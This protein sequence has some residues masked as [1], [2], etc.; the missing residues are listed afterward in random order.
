MSVMDMDALAVAFR[1]HTEGRDRFTRRMAIVLSD[2]DGSTPKQL[3]LR[4]ERLGL[5]RCGSWDWFA[6]NGGITKEHIQEVRGTEPAPRSDRVTS[7][8]EP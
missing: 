2:M 4:C 8:G 5:L 1:S 7:E 3:I 6:A